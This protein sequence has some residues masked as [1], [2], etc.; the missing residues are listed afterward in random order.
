M[1]MAKIIW[2][3]TSK[4]KTPWGEGEGGGLL[5][6]MDSKRDEGNG[7]WLRVNAISENSVLQDF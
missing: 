1:Y 3:S 4:K 6:A 5:N 7:F 2:F